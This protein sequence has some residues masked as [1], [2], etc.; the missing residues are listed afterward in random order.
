[1]NKEDWLKVAERAALEESREA[2]RAGRSP[3]NLSEPLSLDEIA[4]ILRTPRNAGF[5]SSLFRQAHAV[6]ERRFGRR[7]GLFAPL[8]YSNVCA[9]DCV[10]CGYR[11][12]LGSA[13]RRVL[14]EEQIAD[15]A[16]LLFSQG[17]RR[18]LLIASEDPTPK[19]LDM[20][21]C[22]VEAVRSVETEEA[23]ISIS[24]E[25]APR[26]PADFRVLKQAGASSYILFQETYDP[27]LYG[28]MHPSG[29]KSDFQARLD[30][31][32]LAAEGGIE[33][34]GLGVLYGLNEPVGET[35]ALV[36]HARHLQS[37]TGRPV[38]SVSVPRLEPAEGVPFTADPPRPLS[39]FLW[40]RIIAVLRLAL[41]DTDVIVSTR[42]GIALRRASL[43]AGATVFSAG[44]RTDPGGYRSPGESRAQF[45][46][47]DPRS[48]AEVVEDV[49]RL[50]YDPAVGEP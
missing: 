16:A 42:E 32:A 30:G 11:R 48:L 49:R 46:I 5:E 33:R 45:T 22:A 34:I 43:G 10:Y 20:A 1:M 6:R 9:N 50:G 25:I 15:E 8:Y 41:P 13:R 2:T 24:L 14:S 17:H 3:E 12:S 47:G 26:P 37:L 29:P 35:V 27:D 28:R 7:L 21:R 18:I 19:G 44:S 36:A 40:L 23:R 39:D 38:C 31:P 4:R